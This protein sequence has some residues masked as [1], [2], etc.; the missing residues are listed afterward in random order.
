MAARFDIEP[1]RRTTKLALEI[2]EAALVEF[3]WRASLNEVYQLNALEKRRVFDVERDSAAS[4]HR[5]VLNTKAME[6]HPQA[7]QAVVGVFDALYNTSLE[8]DPALPTL[9]MEASPETRDGRRKMQVEVRWPGADE[10]W[11]ADFAGR[12]MR[13]FA[14]ELPPWDKLATANPGDMVYVVAHRANTQL[15]FETNPVAAVVLGHITR[16]MRAKN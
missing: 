2:D 7:P 11:A 16:V 3:R 14:R 1:K 6:R 8:R 9:H 15:M 10:A 4:L 12:H 13:R 5:Y